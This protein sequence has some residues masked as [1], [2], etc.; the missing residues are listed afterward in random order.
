MSHHTVHIAL[1][2]C[3]AFSPYHSSIPIPF[4]WNSLLILNGQLFVQGKRLISEL[5][6]VA[7]HNG[8]SMFT[9]PQMKDIAKVNHKGYTTQ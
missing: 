5:N 1:L 8:S 7:D 6:R 4:W 9:V 2:G 3:G